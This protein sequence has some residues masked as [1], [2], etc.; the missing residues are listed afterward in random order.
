MTFQKETLVI[1][2]NIII[3]F[4]LAFVLWDYIEFEYIDNGIIGIYSEK[5]FNALNDIFRYIV[6]ILI[7]LSF[8]FLTKLYFEKNFSIKIK[9]IFSNDIFTS[10]KDKELSWIIFFLILIPIFFEYLSVSFPEHKLD[11]FHEGQRFSSAYKSSLDGSLWSGSFVTVGIFYETISSRLIWDIFDQISIGLT[12]YLEIFLIFIQKLS[13]VLLLFIF[14][15]FLRLSP[16]FKNIFF[17]SNTLILSFL[18]NYI[19]GVDLLSFRELPIILLS[20]LFLLSIKYNNNFFILFFISLLSIGSM[21]WGIDRGL[22]CNFLILSIL[23]YLLF[24]KEYKKLLFL[25]ILSLIPWFLFFISSKNEFIYFFNNTITIFKEMNYIHGLIHPKPFTNE[26]HSARATKTLL[27]IVFTNIIAIH[28]I[29]SDNKNFSIHF[30]RFLIF[31]ALVCVCSY[32]Y[33]LGRSDGPH[34]KNSFGY[35]LIFISI[36]FSYNFLIYISKKKIKLN[37]YLIYISLIFF[38]IL[39]FQLNFKNIISYNDRFSKFINLEDNFFLNNDEI[40]LINELRTKISNYDCIQLLSNDAALYYLL[41]KKSC[42][43]YYYVWSAASNKTQKLLIDELI[44]TKIII[45]GGPRNSWDLP[46]NKKLHLVYNEL[47]NNF[48]ES[49]KIKEW[50]VFLRQQ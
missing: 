43:K 23:L 29:F 38:I 8:Y 16:L 34:I 22:V 24:L 26:L 3:S 1:S 15:N 12:R 42:T 30:K 37:H 9:G 5:K 35:P 10:E 11:S 21:L 18:S 50:R 28:L 13:L 36:F 47:E 20:I 44:N 7:P 49:Q 46:L 32:L 17:I 31:L 25:F 41:R 45:E 27:A 6:F 40:K 19:S 48:Y 4:C 2:I 39:T 14:T 33:A